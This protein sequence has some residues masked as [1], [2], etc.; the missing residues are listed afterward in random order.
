MVGRSGLFVV[1]E[2]RLHFLNP[3]PKNRNEN[4][5]VRGKRPMVWAFSNQE[6]LKCTTPESPP[7]CNLVLGPITWP[8]MPTTSSPAHFCLLPADLLLCVCHCYFHS[9][10]V[11]FLLASCLIAEAPAFYTD[12]S[13]NTL[14]AS[15][16]ACEVLAF[17]FHPELYIVL[18]KS[19]SFAFGLKPVLTGPLH[20]GS[21]RESASITNITS[22]NIGNN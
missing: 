6:N 8:L 10:P 18:T 15:P 2:D 1:P 4:T 20:F 16:P 13:L 7:R 17:P 11:F 21:L 5:G 12:P 22:S 9:L 3:L 14:D 19:H